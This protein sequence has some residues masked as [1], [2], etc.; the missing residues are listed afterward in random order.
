MNTTTTTNRSTTTTAPTS[1]VVRLKVWP[2]RPLR[3]KDALQQRVLLLEERGQC[4]NADD[5]EAWWQ[6]DTT[7]QQAAALCAGCPVR[8]EC[9]EYAMTAPEA[10][11]VWGGLN[12]ESRRQLAQT[13]AV[14]EGQGAA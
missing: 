10:W 11:G 6:D 12:V 8:N 5:P 9:L 1:R 13:D 4:R 7:A 3:G 2:S 14:D